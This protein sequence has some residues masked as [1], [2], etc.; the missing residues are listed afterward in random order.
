MLGRLIHAFKEEYISRDKV[1]RT[2][3]ELDLHVDEIKEHAK[4]SM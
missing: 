4:E 3:I 2:A 1:R